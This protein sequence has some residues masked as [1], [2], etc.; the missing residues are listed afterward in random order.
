MEIPDASTVGSAL[1]TSGIITGPVAYK[2]LR[3]LD[4][5]QV[6]LNNMKDQVAA[7]EERVEKLEDRLNSGTRDACKPYLHLHAAEGT[8]H[9]HGG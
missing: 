6:E 9:Y 3:S 5:F 1:A 2:L 7:M 8:L 4:K